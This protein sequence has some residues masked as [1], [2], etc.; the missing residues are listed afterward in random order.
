[1]DQET[2]GL[3]E[4]STAHKHLKQNNATR[5][6]STYLMIDRALDKHAD[7]QALFMD[8]SFN[9]PREDI[10]SFSDWRLLTEIK[11]ILKPLYEET[12][13]TQG[14]RDTS[15]AGRLF[16]TLVSLESMMEHLEQARDWYDIQG[17]EE[18]AKIAAS[19]TRGR[20]KRGQPRIH[21]S[22]SP[23]QLPEFI[24]NE[25]THSEPSPRS[26]LVF[27]EQQ[28]LL[29]AILKCW[30]KLQIYYD[31]TDDS[32]LYAAAVILHP[33]YG[34]EHLRA[35]DWNESWIRTALGNISTHIQQFYG[36]LTSQDTKLS[37]SQARSDSPPHSGR[38]KR[39]RIEESGT[40][41]DRYCNL[42]PQHES[43]DV[44]AWW[45]EHQ[46]EFPALSQL[47]LDLWAVPAMSADCERVFSG[48]KLIMTSQSQ[49]MSIDTLEQRM[50]IKQWQRAMFSEGDLLSDTLEKLL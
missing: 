27:P 4:V 36:H 17:N 46:P 35:S 24:R 44:P 3:Q 49:S 25:Y 30:Q 11:D 37:S 50:C 31:K 32:P 28:W 39:R 7:L 19:I 14:S 34:L 20:R 18:L 38:A 33:G 5:W 6:N 12:M 29:N 9:L 2:H 41:L 16:D 43:V 47:A 23:E 21:L 10:L 15:M 1:M 45:R 13:R 42:P 22:A 48:C 26:S 40:E 8:Q